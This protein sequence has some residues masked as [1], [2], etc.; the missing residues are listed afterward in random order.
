MKTPPALA[1]LEGVS[2]VHVNHVGVDSQSHGH[3][4]FLEHG[5]ALDDGQLGQAGQRVAAGRA[6]HQGQ[7][8]TELHGQPQHG[9]QVARVVH[10]DQDV[11]LLSC[12]ESSL[13]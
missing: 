10:A 13:H 9:A 12:Q 4:T 11:S 8:Q 5:A 6:G 7:V 1:Y 2:S 3:A